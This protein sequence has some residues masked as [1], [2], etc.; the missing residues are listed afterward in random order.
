MP[1]ELKMTVD[2]RRKVL[3]IMQ[4]E[5]QEAKRKRRSELLDQAEQLTGQ[6]RKSLIRLLNGD[7]KRKARRRQRGTTYGAEVDDALRVISESVDH[8]CA[9]RL[10]GNLSWLAQ[11]LADH[12]E[13]T[14]TPRL[15][16]Q[17]ERISASTIKRRLKRIR[18][19]EPRLPRRAPRRPNPVTK[20]IPMKRIPWYERRPGYFEV[21]LV[22]HCGPSTSGEYVHTLQ[23]I[24]V[25]TGWS[26]R[27]AVLG[28]SQRAMEDAFRRILAGLPFPIV[29]LHPDNGSEFLN[30]HLIRFWRDA[31]KGIQISRSRPYHKNDNRFVE[32]KNATLVR[33][34]LGRD[35]LDTVEQTIALHH[36]LAKMRLYYNLFQPVTRLEEKIFLPGP[37]GSSRILRRYD[38]PRT[39]FDRLCD[40]DAISDQQRHALCQLRAQTNP[41]QLRK[42]IYDLIDALFALPCATAGHREDIHLTLTHT[43][44]FMKGE[45][46]PVTLSL[47]PSPL[48]G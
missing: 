20:E 32:Q 7:L 9:Q 28:R 40:T 41:R 3:R 16:E 1:D 18:Q 21:A 11:H 48:P 2:E 44:E 43:P 46:S 22:H 30:A 38:Q 34:F 12:G 26:E 19:D 23:L 13:M 14:V 39:P 31:V 47:E 24:D 27:A 8:I 37:N 5:Y 33:A 29:E 35:R 45:G 10:V 42:E 17:L 25:A 15:L 36:L 6:H 4:K